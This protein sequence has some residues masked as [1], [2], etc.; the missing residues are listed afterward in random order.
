MLM[1]AD[2]QQ[3]QSMLGGYVD[4]EL[5]GAERLTVSKHL[6]KCRMCARE[7]ESMTCLGDLLREGTGVLP[8]REDLSGLAPGLLTRIGTE[9]ALSWRHRLDRGIDDLRWL[10]VGMGSV[11]GT[12]ASAFIAIGILLLG[13][14]PIR[15][16]SLAGLMSTVGVPAGTLFVVGTA[17]GDAASPMVLQLGREGRLFNRTSTMQSVVFEYPVDMRLMG[18]FASAVNSQGRLMELA[19]MP[20]A[21]RDYMVAM[22]AE[23]SRRRSSSYV[24][25]RSDAVAVHG[26]LLYENTTVNGI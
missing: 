10:L 6:A 24:G 25:L 20:D 7:V 4:A 26:I 2:C 21:Q 11:L 22:L 18:A 1:T 3:L 19:D 9:A 23:K 14:A 12:A 17:G 15:T 13:P 8:E 16:D 5:S